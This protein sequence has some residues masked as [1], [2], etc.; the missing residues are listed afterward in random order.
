M[1]NALRTVPPQM[2]EVRRWR[3]PCHSCSRGVNIRDSNKRPYLFTEIA[4]KLLG[5]EGL[6]VRISST[7]V[8]YAINRLTI[9]LKPASCRRLEQCRGRGPRR[10]VIDR[11]GDNLVQLMS[12]RLNYRR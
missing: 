4:P 5:Q 6:V 7:N 1:I 12:L 11:H 8:M 2:D 9:P 3:C 10:K